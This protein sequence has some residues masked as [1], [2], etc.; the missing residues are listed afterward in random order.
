LISNINIRLLGD[1]K[2]LELLCSETNDSSL[3]EEF[4]NRFLPDL[5]RECE[6]I[7]KTRKL[8]PHIGIQISHEVLERVR[9]YKSFKRDKIHLKDDRKAIIVYL[10]R[11]ATCLFND[12]YRSQ[13]KSLQ[14]HRTYFDDLSDLAS[15]RS[16]PII[17]NNQQEIAIK[18]FRK[19]NKNEQIVVLKD[20]EYKR[21]YKYLPDDV[22]ESLAEQLGLKKDTIRKI[23]KRAI[24]KIKDLINGLN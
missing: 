24:Q 8:D 14:E 2:L 1:T 22:T 20:L 11:I 19:L 7:C 6:K 15:S 18:L 16:N 3:Y 17:L 9:K 10:F 5:K 23:R 12:H 13:K 21:N 4:V